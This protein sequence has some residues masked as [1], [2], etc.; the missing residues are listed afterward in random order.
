MLF[1]KS[2]RTALLLTFLLV[3]T[4][5]FLDRFGIVT[6]P[7]LNLGFEAVDTNLP[8][9]LEYLFHNL[10]GSLYNGV[11]QDRGM[12]FAISVI[13]QYGFPSFIFLL[14]MLIR[15]KNEEE[16]E[17][18]RGAVRVEPEELRNILLKEIYLK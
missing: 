8:Q 6:L 10:F 5:I 18:K 7:I 1:I 2:L 4:I 16:I 14:I 17:I 12:N 13:F 3:G 11:L 15:R 9:E